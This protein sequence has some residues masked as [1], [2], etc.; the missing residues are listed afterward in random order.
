MKKKIIILIVF[1]L[2]VALALASYFLNNPQN[3]LEKI[4][5][6]MISG[7]TYVFSRSN[8]N[9]EN[10]IVTSRKGDKTKIDTYNFG[11][12]ATT[13][14]KDGNTYYILHAQ[15]EYYIYNN[16]KSD[17]DLLTDELKAIVE[18]NHT[19]GKEK[20]NGTTYYYEEFEGQ[21][22]FLINTY[23]DMD[24]SS[25]KTKFYFK[26]RK[27][28]YIKTEYKI[29]NEETGARVLQNSNRQQL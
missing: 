26:G 23:K 16:S 19:T 25:I 28:E 24:Y 17:Q 9:E 11:E 22:D 14:I 8:K 1:I 2:I 13:L 29:E 27:L 21:T 10:K 15:E 7:Q 3:R 4:Y 20:I 5:N 12:Y 6:K 18:K